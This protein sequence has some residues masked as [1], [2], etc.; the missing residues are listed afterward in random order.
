MSGLR[1]VGTVY[2]Q[3]RLPGVVYYKSADRLPSSRKMPGMRR[4]AKK[5]RSNKI[6]ED[7]N[8]ESENQ[9]RAGLSQRI[10]HSCY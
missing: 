1:L 8:Y 2:N 10:N 7:M 6:L 4:K 5:T 9:N 3:S